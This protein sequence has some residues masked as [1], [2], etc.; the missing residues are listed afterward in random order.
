MGFVSYPCLILQISGQTVQ[1]TVA[2]EKFWQL[3]GL[4]VLSILE[5]TVTQAMR[6]DYLTDDQWDQVRKDVHMIN[7]IKKEQEQGAARLAA[8]SSHIT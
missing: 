4:L 8:T 1:S 2:R 7:K 3:N 5:A 6:L